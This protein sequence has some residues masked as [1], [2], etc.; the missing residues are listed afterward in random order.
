MTVSQNLGQGSFDVTL[1]GHPEAR[2]AEELWTGKTNVKERRKLQNR[3]NRRAFSQF[4][5]MSF[6]LGIDSLH[7]K[8]PGRAKARTEADGS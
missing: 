7:R 2:N 6:R 5:G 3:L 1:L 4:P 8:T